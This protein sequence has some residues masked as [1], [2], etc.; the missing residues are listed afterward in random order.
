MNLIFPEPFPPTNLSYSQF[1]GQDL[2]LL[3]E[4]NPLGYVEYLIY[5]QCYAPNQTGCNNQNVTVPAKNASDQPI[6]MTFEVRLTEAAS[7]IISVLAASGNL[8]AESNTI[9][10]GEFSRKHNFCDETKLLSLV[11]AKLKMQLSIVV[12][13]KIL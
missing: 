3:W 9:T 11:I 8:T 2:I 5:R 10:L 12:L 4:I 13:P 7:Y 1:D 6:M